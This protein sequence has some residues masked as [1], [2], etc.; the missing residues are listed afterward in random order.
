MRRPRRPDGTTTRDSTTARE[1][2]QR[3]KERRDRR[4][5]LQS[6]A[7]AAAHREY[8][9]LLETEATRGKGGRPRKPAA[10]PVEPDQAIAVGI[11]IAFDAVRDGCVGGF[12]RGADS[13]IGDEFR[14]NRRGCQ[15]RKRAGQ[16][17][18]KDRFH[19]VSPR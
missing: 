2:Y 15:K 7:L 11:I 19:L 17:D 9:A 10:Q 12:D 6:E 13:A 1:H 3:E 4:G 16:P 5:P 18:L 14:G 8:R